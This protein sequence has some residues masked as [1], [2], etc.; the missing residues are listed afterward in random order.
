MAMDTLSKQLAFNP[1]ALDSVRAQALKTDTR[2]GIKAAAQQFETYFLQMMLRSMRETLS[3]DGLFDSQET[4]SF[5][6]MFDQQL[7]QTVAQGKGIGLADILIAQIE[8]SLP[9]ADGQLPAVAR[10]VNYDI[11]ASM[12][13]GVAPAGAVADVVPA[14]GAA[15]AG[16]NAFVQ[17]MW[18]HATQVARQLGVP[19]QSV[20]AQAALESGWG[21]KTLKTDAGADSHNIF[22]IKAGSG[23]NGPTVSRD[24]LEY[25]GGLAVK[26][27]EKFRA[28]ASHQEAFADYARLIAG[29][30]RYAGVLNQ[31]AQGFAHGLQQGGYATDPT[32]AGKIMRVLNSPAFRQVLPGDA[33]QAVG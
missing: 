6:E 28:Y 12:E 23:W 31:D 5:T 4:R 15:P 18:P 14:G 8:R 26:S 3:Q 25:K 13:S 19:T 29:N 24:V 16:A 20:L 30:P 1:Q 27:T 17:Q 11:P 10:P 7:S 22:N 32:Y 9:K 33:L 21:Q 2:E